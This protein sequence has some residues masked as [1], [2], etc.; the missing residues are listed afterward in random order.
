MSNYSCNNSMIELQN[1]FM[2]KKFI[3]IKEINL[4]ALLNYFY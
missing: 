1:E 4:Y 3:D 2:E